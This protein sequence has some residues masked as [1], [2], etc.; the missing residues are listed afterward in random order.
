MR[1][2]SVQEF[3]VLRFGEFNGAKNLLGRF[4]RLAAEHCELP[5][6]A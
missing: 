4:T 5:P 3:S 2:T 6:I 1:G